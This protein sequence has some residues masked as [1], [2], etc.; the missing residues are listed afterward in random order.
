[1]YKSRKK[2]IIISSVSTLLLGGFVTAAYF[3]A[4]SFD[5]NEIRNKVESLYYGATSNLNNKF[6]VNDK[7]VSLSDWIFSNMPERIEIVKHTDE[8]TIKHYTIEFMDHD[9]DQA[10]N[11]PG[12]MI[13]SIDFKLENTLF[14]YTISTATNLGGGITPL[15]LG[16]LSFA[17]TGDDLTYSLTN[18]E[19]VV[20]KILLKKNTTN[21]VPNQESFVSGILS[22][23]SL[24]RTTYTGAAPSIN[25]VL[26]N[27]T[28]KDTIGNPIYSSNLFKT[29]TN[30]NPNSFQVTFSNHL[31]PE[32]I[33]TS[34]IQENGTGYNLS[35]TGIMNGV[36]ISSITTYDTYK[37]FWDSTSNTSI[38]MPSI[39][40]TIG[41]LDW[42]SK[43]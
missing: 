41:M 39:F 12:N 26:S 4:T 38:K 22:G 35:Y 37:P 19:D 42:I 6:N 33:L 1:M 23:V 2:I 11:L 34:T 9:Y 28:V 14:S 25:D 36:N 24:E 5:T 7:N 32:T 40:G 17:I 30:P 18:Y 21:V 8:P 3:I 10:K 27:Y 20:S 16:G 29:S 43:L 13:C 31:Q 15:S